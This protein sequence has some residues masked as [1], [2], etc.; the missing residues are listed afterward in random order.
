MRLPRK[1]CSS[2][3]FL[4]TRMWASGTTI[5]NVQRVPE[6]GWPLAPRTHTNPDLPRALHGVAPS[7]FCSRSQCPLDLALKESRYVP[8]DLVVRF[9]FLPP[10]C[11]CQALNSSYV[12]PTSGAKLPCR[13]LCVPA[14]DKLTTNDLK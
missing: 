2:A 14:G 5:T 9:V 13:P 11:I 3:T 10:M 6:E 8:V 4:I 7:G 12:R 1:T